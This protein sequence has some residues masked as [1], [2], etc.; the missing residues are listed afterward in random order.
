MDKAFSNQ[1]VNLLE[2]YW[3]LLTK[4]FFWTLGPCRTYICQNKKEPSLSQ[5]ILIY[6][7]GKHKRVYLSVRAN[8][9][10]SICQRKR[11]YLS[12]RANESISIC[13]RKRAYLS[14]R[15][16]GSISICQTKRIYLSVRANG[17][18]SIC[19]TKRV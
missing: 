16:N 14:V 18:I 19:Q 15:A 9:Y 11:A 12:V 10:I 2:Q 5:G 4:I 1:T 3:L 17:S 8:G 6:L 7:Y 13:Q